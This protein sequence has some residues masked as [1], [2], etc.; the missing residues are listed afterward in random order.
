MIEHLKNKKKLKKHF[1]KYIVLFIYILKLILYTIHKH[2]VFAV[3]I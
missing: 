3:L 2:A 1:K